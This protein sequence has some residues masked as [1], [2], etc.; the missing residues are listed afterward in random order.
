MAYTSDGYLLTGPNTLGPEEAALK[1]FATKD[2]YVRY[3]EGE[4]T[5]EEIERAARE[6]T[7]RYRVPETATTADV[8]ELEPAAG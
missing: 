3:L 5:L 2:L 7:L 1:P 8:R 4:A 6:R